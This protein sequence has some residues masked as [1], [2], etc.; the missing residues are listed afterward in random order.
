MMATAMITMVLSF[1][2]RT[3]WTLGQSTGFVSCFTEGVDRVS[4][5]VFAAFSS[6]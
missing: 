1:R 5:F 2:L 3:M 4:C 6:L